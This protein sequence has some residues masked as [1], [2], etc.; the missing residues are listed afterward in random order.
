MQPGQR[1]AY[2]VLV[3]VRAVHFWGPQDGGRHVA[4]LHLLLHQDFVV[5][6]GAGEIRVPPMVRMPGGAERGV[7]P[8]R[9]G[10]GAIRGR[11]APVE[12][13]SGIAGVD[14]ALSDDLADEAG[15][16]D[17]KDGHR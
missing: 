1:T 5:G 11:P 14:E 15:I 4:R 17:E 9:N 12:D 7:F 8:E 6:V 3:V 2:V 13:G 16:A 10:V